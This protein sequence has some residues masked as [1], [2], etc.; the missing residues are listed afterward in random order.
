MTDQEVYDLLLCIDEGYKP[1]DSENCWISSIERLTWASVRILPDSMKYL[2]N[3]TVL[4]LSNTEVSDIR[5]LSCLKTL[6]KLDLKNTKVSNIRM[7]KDFKALTTLDLTNTNVS[8]ISPLSSLQELKSL[9]LRKTKVNNIQNLQ[10]LTALIALDLSNTMVSDIR[11]LSRLYSLEKLDLHDTWVKDISVISGLSVLEFLNLE[12]TRIVDIPDLSHLFALKVLNLKNTKVEDISNLTGLKSLTDLN[13]CSTKVRD[14]CALS[15]LKELRSLNLSNTKIVDIKVLSDLH[16]LTSL[17][18]KRT[19]VSDISALSGLENLTT[20]DL[21]ELKLNAIPK[22]LFDLELDFIEDDRLS[23]QGIFIR[24][25]KLKDQLIEIF[26]QDRSLV[27]AY[28]SSQEKVPINECKVIFLGDPDVGKTYSIK[29]LLKNGEKLE[30]YDKNSTPGIEIT[31]NSTTIE[32]T[33]IVVNYWD[34]GGQEIQHAMHRLFLTERTLYVVFLNAELDSLIP[35]NDRAE[36]WLKNINSFAAGAPVLLVINKI[37]KNNSPKF[38]EE[39]FKTEYDDQIKDVVRMSALMDEPDV[40]LQELQG[41]INKIIKELSMASMMVPKSWRLLLNN[42]FDTSKY[43]LTSDEFKDKCEFYHIEDYDR[44]HDSLLDLFQVI[45]ASFNYYKNRSLG[46]F[47]LLNP[48]WLANAIY[49]IISN[50]KTAANNGVIE[51]EDLYDLLKED[52]LHSIPVRRVIPDL[53]YKDVEVNYILGVIRMFHMSYPMKDGPEFFPMLCDENRKIS[54]DE[55][56]SDN[57]LHYIFRYNYLPANVIH[58]LIV[59]M[60]QDLIEECV[61]YNV[62]VFRNEYR[63]QKAYITIEGND[64]HIYVDDLGIYNNPNE[65]LTPIQNLVRAINNDMNLSAEE[66]VT[67][68]EGDMEAA[69]NV[70]DLEGNLEIGIERVFNKKLKKAI[71]YRDVARFYK[72][73]VK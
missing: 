70:E 63:H 22:F 61:W 54:V 27:R 14:I 53:R 55:V 32:D 71:N 67:Y 41:S 9:C 2:D 11:D 57:A 50:S 68:R 59:E 19:S 6:I 26:S 34:F 35:I 29:R 49:T 42:L 5:A 13:L 48:K 46:D 7:F 69:I 62:A 65:Y 66:Y 36:Y 16:K 4:D 47:M 3:I 8:N 64:L 23:G 18:L 58:R 28:Y 25:L 20:L 72:I 12:N 60:R 31:V 1:T 44:I 45:G 24:G 15:Q 52:T 21:R 33:D 39:G 73:H 10:G 43:Y 51:Q 30:K 37:D 38:N 17:N 40:F 56:M